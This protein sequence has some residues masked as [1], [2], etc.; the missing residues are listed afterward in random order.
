MATSPAVPCVSKDCF[1]R[2]FVEVPELAQ[3][4]LG[5]RTV[6]QVFKTKGGR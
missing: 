3:A 5:H 4:P 1:V 2:Y 6:G